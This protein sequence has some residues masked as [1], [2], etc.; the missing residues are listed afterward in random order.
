MS[1]TP[2]E[3]SSK[4]VKIED[5]SLIGVLPN[6]LLYHIFSFLND[7]K[8]LSNITLTCKNWNKIAKVETTPSLWKRAVYQE[9][10]FS[11]KSWAAIFGKDVIKQEKI[12]EDFDSLDIKE[13]VSTYRSIKSVYRIE[14]PREALLTVRIPKSLNGGLNLDSLIDISKKFF[15]VSDVYGH[16]GLN[17]YQLA[18]HLRQIPIKKS[19]WVVMTKQLLPGTVK[20]TY[21]EQKELIDSLSKT[22]LKGF[23]VAKVIEVAT[24]ILAYHSQKQLKQ[25][26]FQTGK[27]TRCEEA[28]GEY[29]L[30]VGGLNPYGLNV[31]GDGYI[32]DNIG[33]VAIK[34][35]MPEAYP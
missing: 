35:L 29:Q 30:V 32:E 12:D 13:F 6:E 21:H 27:Y 33:V 11:N 28:N 16:R 23:R 26:H 5:D 7:L 25:E 31:N 10:T 17:C 2:T 4:R 20:K 34:T 14:K 18:A 1:I 15:L 8:S 24:S 9:L 3:R 22:D 19:Y